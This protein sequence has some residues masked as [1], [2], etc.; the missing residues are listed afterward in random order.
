MKKSNILI[1]LKFHFF[2]KLLHWNIITKS[3]QRFTQIHQF[4]QIRVIEK[5][6]QLICL[7]FLC[8]QKDCFVKL[9]KKC[10]DFKMIFN[11]NVE[12]FLNEDFRKKCVCL[13]ERQIRIDI[14]SVNFIISILLNL[15]IWLI[16]LRKAQKKHSL[17]NLRKPV[18]IVLTINLIFQTLSL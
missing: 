9:I 16:D 2:N 12:I 10:L 4:Y 17:K 6:K 13:S 5:I 15:A 3:K 1:C 8:E 11:R 18:K 14:L 7:K